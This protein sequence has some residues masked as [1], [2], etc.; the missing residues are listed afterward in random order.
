MKFLVFCGFLVCYSVSAGAQITPV[1]QNVLVANPAADDDF[2]LP[3]YWT[4][5]QTPVPLNS[6]QAPTDVD[7]LTAIFGTAGSMQELPAVGSGLT[8]FTDNSLE[9]MKKYTFYPRT[10]KPEKDEQKQN[11]LLTPLPP[12][13]PQAEP[14]IPPRKIFVMPSNYASQLLQQL[15]HQQ[16][17]NTTIPKDVRITFQPNDARLSSQN[18]KWIKLF[19][20]YVLYDPRLVLV[21][22]L[23]N[24]NWNLQRA[25]LAMILQIAVESGLSAQQIQVYSSDRDENSIVLSYAH[26]GTLTQIQPFQERIKPIRTHKTLTW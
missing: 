16:G 18:L 15:G 4:A 8:P 11:L 2:L 26:N 9:Q 22:R 5:T 6:L 1:N 12:V 20:T 25:R 23:S 17:E 21:V 7:I 10:Q 13:P 3:S 19:A 14:E 24:H